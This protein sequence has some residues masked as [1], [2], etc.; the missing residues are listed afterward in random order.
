MRLRVSRSTARASSCV[1][2]V[3]GGGRGGS[4]QAHAA[5]AAAPP[6][7][8]SG[9]VYGAQVLQVA[10]VHEACRLQLLRTARRERLGGAPAAVRRTAR[11]EGGT[12]SVHVAIR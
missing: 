3:S 4:R 9:Q 11:T 12:A 7:L 10:P 2:S 6:R 8:A 5:A 1:R